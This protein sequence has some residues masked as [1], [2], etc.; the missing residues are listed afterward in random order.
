MSFLYNTPVSISEGQSTSLTYQEVVARFSSELAA[1]EESLLSHLDPRNELLRNITTYITR[2]GGKRLRPLLVILCSKLKG[3]EG[4][5]H[6]LLGNVVEY[7]HAATLLHDDVLD[8]AEI[9]R[10]NPSAN[11]KWGNHFA[12]LGG[13]FLYTTAFDLLLQRFPRDIIQILCRA[14]LDMINGEVL[15]RQWR[16]RI[17]IPEATYFE[18]VSLKTASLISA[19]CRTGAIL[20][21][22]GREQIE[23][24]SEFGRLLGMAF[25]VI[26][27]TLD[28][29]A[30]PGKLG[31]ALGGDLR[32]RTVTLPLIYL[33]QE[34]RLQE[35]NAAMMEALAAEEISES[36]VREIISLLDEQGCGKKAMEKAASLAAASKEYLRSSSPSPLYPALSAAA[37]YI[38]QRSH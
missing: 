2:S 22:A 17:D 7:L 14:S 12:V 29:T 27:D 5:D 38:I 16:G 26:D 37:D 11:H 3:Y 6:I 13:D 32:Q 23:D 34:G 10:G 4:P 28:Y 31:K 15:Q 24:L 36:T 1:V 18:V 8:R 20:G 33:F 30:D 19:C 25:Q 35:K 21:G 9:R